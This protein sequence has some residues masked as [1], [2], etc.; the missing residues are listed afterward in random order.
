MTVHIQTFDQ[1]IF[2]IKTRT[3]SRNH[4]VP[5]F[6]IFYFLTPYINTKINIKFI[7]THTHI[8][9]YIYIYIYIYIKFLLYI[10]SVYIYIY[11]LIYTYIHGYK[12]TPPYTPRSVQRA[13]TARVTF[14][15]ECYNIWPLFPI[16]LKA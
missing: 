10:S 8:F 6:F 5:F 13:L 1:V 9:I 16:L 3:S 14:C 12:R 11:R 7:Y 4:T 2:K 15:W